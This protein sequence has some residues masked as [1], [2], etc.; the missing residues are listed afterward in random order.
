MS[1]LTVYLIFQFV[2]NS[3]RL[4]FYLE[5]VINGAFW[6]HRLRN[7]DPVTGT[8]MYNQLTKL[9]N[10]RREQKKWWTNRVFK[11]VSCFKKVVISSRLKKE[12]SRVR[13]Q[14]K[15]KKKKEKKSCLEF[16]TKKGGHVSSSRP[17][18]LSWVQE[19]KKTSRVRDQQKEIKKERKRKNLSWV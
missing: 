4:F 16:K 14:K 8:R 1:L 17:K 12:T 5:L 6:Q 15:N 9:I 3:S 7:L 2:K 10:E 11:R 19:Q 13:G 18:K